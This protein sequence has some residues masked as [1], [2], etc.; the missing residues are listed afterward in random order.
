MI[1]NKLRKWI[2]RAS[3]DIDNRIENIT[4]REE[5]VCKRENDVAIRE[6][7]VVESEK[8]LKQ[9]QE[10]V[11]IK[12]AALGK[13]KNLKW[14]IICRQI[15]LFILLIFLIVVCIK[16]NWLKS[17]IESFD[18]TTN[19]MNVKNVMTI[20]VLSMT[21]MFIIIFISYLLFLIAR[22]IRLNH[23]ALQKVDLLRLRLEIY[24]DKDLAALYRIDHELEMIYRML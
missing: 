9:E 10:N 19:P 12:G 15:G 13:L 4:M 6:K 7:R 20:V 23:N 2:L 8:E 11:Q 1:N 5:T 24:K 14:R 16:S 18:S 22:R 21:I 3:G 17:S